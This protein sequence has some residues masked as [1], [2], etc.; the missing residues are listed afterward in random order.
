MIITE[1][2]N[3]KP[4]KYAT[5]CLKADQYNSIFICKD[6][7][8]Q[9]L[10]IDNCWQPSSVYKGILQEIEFEYHPKID[11]EYNLISRNLIQ[12]YQKILDEDGFEEF[13]KQATDLFNSNSLGAVPN[14]MAIHVVAF[15]NDLEF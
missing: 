5:H 7:E 3:L 8:Q 9:L 4:W 14:I 15:N 6:G 10:F 11:E 12:N 2:M 1:D 13:D